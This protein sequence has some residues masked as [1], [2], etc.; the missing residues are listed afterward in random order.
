[1]LWRRV[2]RLVLALV[3]VAS[4]A[5]HPAPRGAGAVTAT[6]I[7]HLVVLFQ[8]N[9]SFDHYFGTYAANVDGQPFTAGAGTPAV[10]GLTP[11]LLS[12]NPNAAQPRRLGGPGE[13]VTCDQDHADRAEQLAFNG[14]AMDRFVENTD[15][16]ACPSA[17]PAW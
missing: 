14:G 16:G 7:H 11:E 9:V 2:V 15:G 3:V 17:R 13:Q 1:M 12:H 6:P 5:R 10:D 4:C 8:E